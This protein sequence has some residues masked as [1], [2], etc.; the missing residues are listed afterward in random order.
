MKYVHPLAIVT[1]AAALGVVGCN[2]VEGT[3][4]LDKEAMRQAT[5][6]QSPKNAEEARSQEMFLALLEQ[7]DA[8]FVLEPGGSVSGGVRFGGHAEDAPRKGTWKK[9]DDLVVIELENGR[10]KCKQEG[11]NKLLCT[12][13]DSKINELPLI[14]TAEK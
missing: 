7:F 11:K 2:K 3:Y 12:S 9:E 1:I 13:D 4:A 14:K 8:R 5:L 10:L 6:A